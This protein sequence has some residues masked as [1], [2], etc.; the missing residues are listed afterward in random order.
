MSLSLSVC[1]PV[2]GQLLPVD[3]QLRGFLFAHSAKISC[4]ATSTSKYILAQ[5]SMAS[6]DVLADY[7][8]QTIS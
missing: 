7:R 1:G 8:H 4:V 6:L 2:P 5:E 3:S